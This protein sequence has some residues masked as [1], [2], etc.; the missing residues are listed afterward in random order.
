MPRTPLSWSLVTLAILIVIGTA[1]GL[2]YQDYQSVNAAGQ[3]P[4]T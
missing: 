1:S 4:Q 3:A 2:L